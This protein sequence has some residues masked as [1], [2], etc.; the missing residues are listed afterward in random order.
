[1]ATISFQSGRKKLVV[2]WLLFTLAIFVVFLA[3]TIT[4]RYT[5][6]AGDVWQWLFSFIT[7]ALT[8]MLGVL[9]AQMMSNT[10]DTEVDRF[11]FRLAFGISV[12]FLGLFL[13]APVLVPA[14][15]IRANSGR[16]F[17]EQQNILQAFKTYD[18]FLIPVQGLTMLSLGLFFTK[19]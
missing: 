5:T 7:P 11:Y 12:F 19:K 3:Q 10:P 17:S 15:H 9:A 13:L 2:L 18:T 14:L 4:G 1:M 6:H 16:A 8:L